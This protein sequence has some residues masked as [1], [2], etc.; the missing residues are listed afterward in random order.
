MAIKITHHNKRKNSPDQSL[1]QLKQGIT[2]II[3]NYTSL[4]P[5]EGAQTDDT[6][7]SFCRVNC[8]TK[9]Q[10]NLNEEIFSNHCQ[11]ET[12]YIGNL[13]LIWLMRA[14]IAFFVQSRC[15]ISLPLKECP[16]ILPALI[17]LQHSIKQ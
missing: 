1:V 9:I 4:K 16:Y 13:Y 3:L 11:S 10:F 8:S 6:D 7:K 12:L 5:N 14:F 17:L 15:D 2:K